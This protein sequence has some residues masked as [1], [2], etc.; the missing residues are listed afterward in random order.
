M[1]LPDWLRDLRFDDRVL[2][3]LLAAVVVPVQLHLYRNTYFIWSVPSAVLAA[4]MVTALLL[5]HRT[6]PLFGSFFLLA[7]AASLW[8]S[9][10]PGHSLLN[11]VW[12]SLYL[13]ALGA[14]TW[15]PAF[16]ALNGLLL[17]AGLE[18]TL[19]LDIF[20]LTHYF[21]GSIHYVAGAQGLLFLPICFAQSVRRQGYLARGLYLLGAGLA[22]FLTLN[23]GSRAVYLPFALLL[24]PL[25][26]RSWKSS[27]G[28][29]GAL[30]GLAIPVAV[31]LTVNLAL[32]GNPLQRAIGIRAVATAT[33]VTGGAPPAESGGGV[34]AAREEDGVRSR[35][36]MWGQAVSIGME[37]PFGT[38]AATFREVV[39]SFQIHPS[40]GFSSAHNVFL[41]T[42]ATGGWLRLALLLGLIVPAL[43]RGW[44]SDRWPYALGA[45]G[46]WMTLG[47]DITAQMPAVMALAFAS[48]GP[49][50]PLGS[51]QAASASRYRLGPISATTLSRLRS[52]AALAAGLVSLAAL[53]WWYAPCAGSR[54]VVERHLAFRPDVRELLP[55]L[56][57]EQRH[58]LAEEAT[59]LNPN[60][61]WAWQERFEAAHS[62]EERL[63]LAESVAARFP[64][65][66][67]VVFLQWAEL[68]LAQGR[69]AE[70]V[71][72][73]EAG[74]EHFPANYRP[75]GV[76]LVSRGDQ[77]AFWL[78]R[79]AEILL[80]AE[81]ARSQ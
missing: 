73:V 46:L 45:A 20:G 47:F 11:I 43:L 29:L 70:A 22:L 13:A 65:S 74:L 24:I 63:V 23:S 78:K 57:R 2:S 52:G 69:P 33:A 4:S 66:T 49:L 44:L 36:R 9:L 12:E 32:P 30:A 61:L 14:A 26:W 38:G 37:R 35:L 58:E 71:R 17:V 41:E 31:V 75:A 10:A 50:T 62:D 48:L 6:I 27:S 34:A 3:L 19:P 60:S 80:A 72:A 1:R 7:G 79:A 16:V 15:T 40:V 81:D 5:G 76:P 55:S 18:Q 8:W 21:S 77:Q 53:V 56:S 68:A 51:S 59:R 39:H 28:P 25:L 54:C 42:F 64:N 67:P